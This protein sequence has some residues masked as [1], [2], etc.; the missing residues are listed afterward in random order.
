MSQQVQTPTPIFV[1]P[2]KTKFQI[3]SAKITV[4]MS[5]KI[6]KILGE[7]R[8]ARSKLNQYPMEPGETFEV[9]EARIA[10][11]DA[12]ILR[13]P[14]E[15]VEDHILRLNTPRMDVQEMGLPLLNRIGK[16]LFDQPE[17]SE[18]EWGDVSLAVAK[19][20]IW[21]ILDYA[22]CPAQEFSPK[23]LGR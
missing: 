16:E 13:R 20:Y 10:E 21:S 4:N 12:T 19:N 2:G 5:K 9:W 23:R 15:E 22:D 7:V 3:N 14:D 11:V 18:E 1:W 6:G 8:A 17:I